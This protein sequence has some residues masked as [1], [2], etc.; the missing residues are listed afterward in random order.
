MVIARLFQRYNRRI[1]P[2]RDSLLPGDHLWVRRAG[3][4]HHGLYI[5]NGQV[6]HYAGWVEGLRAGPL[7]ETSL[8][9]FCGGRTLYRRTHVERQFSRQQSVARARSRLG[10]NR[11]NVHA[12]NCEHF[13]YWAIN[14]DHHSQQMD[15]VD[16]GLGLLHPGLEATR[17]TLG[18]D[19]QP[20]T[21]Q[22]LSP[23]LG[24]LALDWG[25]KSAARWATGPY[26]LAVYA[27]YRV[28]RGWLGRRRQ[29][30]A[31]SKQQSTLKV[32]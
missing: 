4:S 26:G 21:P 3:Y 31:L 15:W 19:F 14:G 8:S 2:Q 6:V 12:N 32:G 25:V 10:E 18:R 24:Q 9:E 29:K 11:Y 30:R 22:R 13:C 27:S 28:G 23:I 7:A 17:K 20:G 5:G 1:D 16:L